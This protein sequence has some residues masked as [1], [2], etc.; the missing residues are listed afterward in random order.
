MKIH[1]RSQL[2]EGIGAASKHV[3]SSMADLRDGMKDLLSPDGLDVRKATG[4]GPAGGVKPDF[5]PRTVTMVLSQQRANLRAPSAASGD[6][7][8]V[9]SALFYYRHGS[10]LYFTD[11]QGGQLEFRVKNLRGLPP[12][13]GVDYEIQMLRPQTLFKQAKPQQMWFR[14]ISMSIRRSAI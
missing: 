4:Q 11:G 12:I 1:S 2:Q 7:S 8:V 9:K 10:D 6:I 3:L 13:L 14:L 5:M